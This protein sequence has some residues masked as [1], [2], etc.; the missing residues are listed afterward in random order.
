MNTLY[1]APGTCAL[2]AHIVLEWIGEPYAIIKVDFHSPEY[3]KINPAGAVPALDYGADSPLTQCAA[4]LK[5]LARTHPA[6]DLLGDDDPV[7]SAELERW[8]SFIT[9]DLHPAFF[10]IYFPGRYTVSKEPAAQAEVKAAGV[11]LV[12]VKLALLEAHLQGR[13]WIVGDRRTII[14]AYVT[15]MLN[16][17]AALLP[18]GLQSYPAVEAH[19]AAML[20]DKAVKRVTLAETAA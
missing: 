5:Y 13:T 11:E 7:S 4:I 14:D 8:S 18:D 17:A 1:Y 6:V 9:G 15:P 20:G 3:R 19:H 16:W 12:K 2:A 10:P